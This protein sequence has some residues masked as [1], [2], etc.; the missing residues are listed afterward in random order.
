MAE[1][2]Y[3]EGRNITYEFHNANGERD[4]LKA[5]AEKLV[6]DKHDV[7]VTSSTTA[8][9]PVARAS[10]GTNVPVVF[11]SAGN[12][13]EF[14][15]SYASSGNNITG[16]SSSSLDLIDKRM[17]LLKELTP[18]IKR[19]IAL[20]VPS[21]TN[22]EEV[23]RLILKAAKKLGLALVEVEPSGYEELKSKIS[24]FVTRK[25]GDA[26]FLP[27]AAAVIVVV[28]EIAQQAIKERLPVVGPNIE[29]VKRGVLAAYSSDYF[30]LGQQGAVLVDKILKGA[31]PT[32]LPIE[33][34][35]KLKLALNLKTAK[36]IGL[37]IPREILL[38]ANEVTD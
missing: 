38:R 34:P 32:D 1:L 27:P 26:V 23:R 17:E 8:T 31:R 2:G 29:N 14:I 18:G 19:V 7:I 36:A 22:Y 30:A 12:P 33:Q 6:K 28:E 11:L 24:G 25:L 9:A 16:I 13:L 3:V 5:M 15:K 20:Q 21:G 10:A 37:K 35:Y 4:A